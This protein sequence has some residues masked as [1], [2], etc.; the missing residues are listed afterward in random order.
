[1]YKIE[2]IIRPHLF[3]A[4]QDALHEVNVVGLTASDCRGTGRQRTVTHSFRGSQYSGGTS[5]R[6]RL[7]VLVTEAQ[8]ND[9]VDAI[10]KAATT[11]EVGDGKIFVTKLTDVVR[12]RTNEHGESALS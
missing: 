11:G 3:E 6:L 1:M 5:P 7:E 12:I 8:L 2:A 4:V 10:Q 9:A